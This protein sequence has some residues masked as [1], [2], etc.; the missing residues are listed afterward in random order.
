MEKQILALLQQLN[1]KV[2]KI[3]GTLEEHS[4]ILKEHSA[5]LN[6][7]S[8]ILEE[9]ST[10]LEQHGETLKEHGRILSAL[11]TGQE[12]LKAEISEMRLQNAKEFGEIKE[13][14]K[15][16]EDSIEILEEENWNNKKNI[17][18]V[19]KTIGLT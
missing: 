11:R 18:R 15:S 10:M 3:G 1:D 14:L 5:I 12:F 7:H 19:K 6:T 16:H 4:A 2:D 8:D 17:L 13:Q 9:H